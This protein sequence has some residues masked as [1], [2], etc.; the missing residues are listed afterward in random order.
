MY[1]FMYMYACVHMSACVL[2]IDL[3]ILFDMP[4]K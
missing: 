1:A 3:K 2:D 4:R